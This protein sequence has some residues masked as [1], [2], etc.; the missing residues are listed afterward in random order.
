MGAGGGAVWVV[1]GTHGAVGVYEGRMSID[2]IV[3]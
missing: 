3:G 1:D 2:K